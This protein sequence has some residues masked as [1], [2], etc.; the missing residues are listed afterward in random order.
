VNRIE[1]FPEFLILGKDS[2]EKGDSFEIFIKDY[3][4]TQG[5]TNIES[6]R[7]TAMQIDFV[8]LDIFSQTTIYGEAKGYRK[9]LK[10]N[11]DKVFSFRSKVEVYKE[12]HNLEYVKPVYVATSNFIWEIEEINLIMKKFY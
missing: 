1:N 9:N 7:E 11:N 10:V 5:Y 12:T 8:A 2:K 3:L 4:S 6:K